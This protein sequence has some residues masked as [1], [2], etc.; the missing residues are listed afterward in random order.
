MLYT[1]HSL[2]NAHFAGGE[3]ELG[4]IT[5]LTKLVSATFRTHTQTFRLLSPHALLPIHSL[6]LGYSWL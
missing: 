3:E 6:G 1:L 2:N 4:E 5:S